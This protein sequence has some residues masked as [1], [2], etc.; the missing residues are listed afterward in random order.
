[1]RCVSQDDH[2]CTWLETALRLREEST[3]VPGF[4]NY[5]SPSKSLTSEV[6]DWRAVVL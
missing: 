4:K 3:V 6:I 1:M 5:P 2:G